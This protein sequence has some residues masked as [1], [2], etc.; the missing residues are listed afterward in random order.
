[1]KILADVLLEE[2]VRVRK[3]LGYYKEIGPAGMFGSTMIEQ[4]LENADKAI[5]TGDIVAM[6]KANEDLKQIK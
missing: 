5:M 6:L 1:M 3:I 4:S 2:L